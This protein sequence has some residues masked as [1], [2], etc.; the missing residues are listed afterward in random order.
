[1]RVASSGAGGIFHMEVDGI[2][3]TG[4]V[5]VPDTGAWQT[6]RTITVTGVSLTSG[7]HV[8]CVVMDTN[9]ATGSIGNFNWFA[10]R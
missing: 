9:G 6:W 1:M 4:P 5:G 7:T 3:K 2:D 8:V 10:V